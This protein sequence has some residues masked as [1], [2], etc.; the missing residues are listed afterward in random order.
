VVVWSLP[1]LSSLFP[2]EKLQGGHVKV[3]IAPSIINLTCLIN[4]LKLM[5]GIPIITLI[6][7]EIVNGTL[8]GIIVDYDSIAQ[9]KEGIVRE[10]DNMEIRKKLGKKGREAFLRKYNWSA[11]EQKLYGIYNQLILNQ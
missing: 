4:Y 3:S 9:T 8:C 2:H 10:R 5:C 1:L 11:V 7:N 6:T